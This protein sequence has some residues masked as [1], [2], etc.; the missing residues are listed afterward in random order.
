MT[1]PSAM[2]HGA[3][4][5]LHVTAARRMLPAQQ[6]L[7]KSS[8]S[9]NPRPVHFAHVAAQH[10]SSSA[11]PILPCSQV[12]SPPDVST[13]HGATVAEQSVFA[14]RMPPVQQLIKRRYARNDSEFRFVVH[15]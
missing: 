15:A 1:P 2:M 12:A 11:P 4:F 14:R 13:T 10:T 8:P 3:S 6:S 7:A 5:V 9:E